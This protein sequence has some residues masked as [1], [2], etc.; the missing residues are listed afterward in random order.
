LLAM[1]VA[2]LLEAALCMPKF[3]RPSGAAA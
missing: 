3:A 1:L 2:L